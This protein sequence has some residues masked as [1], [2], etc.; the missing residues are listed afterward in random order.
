MPTS[1]VAILLSIFHLSPR[2]AERAKLQ[3]LLIIECSIL[4]CT[5]GNSSGFLDEP[6]AVRECGK[7]GGGQG[8]GHYTTKGGKQDHLVMPCRDGE[9]TSLHI[10]VT[11]WGQEAWGHIRASFALGVL[12]LAQLPAKSPLY[13][14]CF[15]QYQVRNL[16]ADLA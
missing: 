12:G 5:K 4:I 15:C 8:D 1:E 11:P 13:I 10:S 3:V 2:Q 7:G 6:N 9:D 14:L 16:P